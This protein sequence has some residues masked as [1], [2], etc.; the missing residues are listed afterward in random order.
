MKMEIGLILI[1]NALCRRLLAGRLAWQNYFSLTALALASAAG[2]MLL[3]GCQSPD[4]SE[5]AYDSAMRASAAF[6][7]AGKPDY[8]TNCLQEG[9][10]VS[11]TFRYS[12][13]FNTVQKI[14]I[15]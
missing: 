6:H 5:D 15:D 2:C 11:I 13:N 9:D 10:V 1:W 12:T 4:D 8:S 7:Q 3:A 14:G